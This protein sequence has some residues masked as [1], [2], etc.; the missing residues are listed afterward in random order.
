MSLEKVIEAHASKI[1]ADMRDEI[2]NA[3]AYAK[4]AGIKLPEYYTLTTS[5]LIKRIATLEVKLR[6]SNE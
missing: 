4:E 1:A 2:D 3:A 6:L 5:Y